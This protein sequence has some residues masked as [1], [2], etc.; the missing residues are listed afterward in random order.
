MLE[1]DYIAVKGLLKAQKERGRTLK[2]ASIF[3][4]NT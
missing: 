1:K 2:K 3:L 4:E